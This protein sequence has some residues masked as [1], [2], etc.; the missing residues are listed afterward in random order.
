MRPLMGC[1]V[2]VAIA[3]GPDAGAAEHAFAAA[4]D[5]LARCAS[6]WSFQDPGSVLSR[7]N[8]GE[9]V[10][11]DRDT[12]RLLRLARGLMRA[13][14]GL[15]DCTV[16]GALI[17]AGRLPDHGGRAPL[18]RG[19]A[20]DIEV[21]RGW[22]RLARPVRLT[23]DGV[24][25]GFAVDLAI[26]VLRRHG[27]A[28]GII[29]AGGDLRAFGAVAAPIERRELSGR[30][31]PLGTLCDAAV[32]TSRVAADDRD[33]DTFPALLIG[34]PGAVPAPGVWTVLA[35][36]AWRADA[37]TK[38]AAAAPPAR[39]AQCVEALGGLLITGPAQAP[40]HTARA[41]LAEA[42]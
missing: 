6:A 14:G 4:F 37:L 12:E 16:G 15:F 7:L 42:A 1:Y 31:V 34:D 25:K 29:N 9:M 17:A 2:E 13:S 21:G 41:Q 3:A 28:A 10:D 38:V 36:R 5:S 11:I 40:A 27:I 33:A 19:R 18:P 20:D 23:L 32:A 8:A 26:D 24:A 35:R 39:R 22:A 30:R